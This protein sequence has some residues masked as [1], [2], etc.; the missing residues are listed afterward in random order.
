MPE[1]YEQHVKASFYHWVACALLRWR[2]RTF[3]APICHSLP[4]VDALLDARRTK[5]NMFIS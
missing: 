3:T 4:V 5:H 1:I 2:G